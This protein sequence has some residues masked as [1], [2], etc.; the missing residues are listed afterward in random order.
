MEQQDVYR[1]LSKKLMMENSTVIP[2][3]WRAVCSE[4]EADLVN[5]LPAS[6]EQ[7]VQATGKVHRRCR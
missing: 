7:L 4:E 6:L 3:I 2:K 5:L 1:E